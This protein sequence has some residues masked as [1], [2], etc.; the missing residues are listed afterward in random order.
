MESV[1]ASVP[2]LAWPMAAD[3][4]LNARMVVEH[5]GVGVRVLARNGSVRGFVSSRSVENMVRELMEGEK[6]KE[7]RNK[8][9]EVGEAARMAMEEGGSSWRS[10][11]LLI[12]EVCRKN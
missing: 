2:I 9:K 11:D 5:L 1:C 7:V 12:E 6:G 8:A 10:L 4:Y 3:Q